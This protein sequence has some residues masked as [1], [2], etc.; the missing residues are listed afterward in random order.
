MARPYFLEEFDLD[1]TS[2]KVVDDPAP[3]SEQQ[4]LESFEQGYKAGWDDATAAQ[5]QDQSRI[6]AGLENTL[7]DL[8]F[9]FHEARAHV[10]QGVE[11][12]VR[13][14]VE[15]ILPSF[16]QDGLP[17]LVA[18][19]I[20]VALGD[21]TDRPV[22]LSVSPN[23]RAAVEAALPVDPGFP[24]TIKEEATLGDGQVFLNL[25]ATEEVLDLDDAIR[26]VKS[27]IGDF[28][29]INQRMHANG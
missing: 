18:E 27:A 24:I 28:F 19:R 26:T 2:V 11:P 13:E 22:V 1:H 29:E 5:F 10:L 14:L 25:G 4:K 17:D 15:K 20:N 16:A 7:K 21:M 3:M 12:L 9:T 6:T 23:S 8:S